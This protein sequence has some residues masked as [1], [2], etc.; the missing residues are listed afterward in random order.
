[1]AITALP[2]A[3]SRTTPATFSTQ[4][5]AF[6]AALGLFV[7][8]ANALA[9]AMNLNDTTANST[10]SVAI[11][12]G[13]KTFTVDTGKSFEPGMSVKIASE[14]NPSKWMHGD[15][16]TY[17]TVTGE[18]V[19]NILQVLSSGTYTDWIVT[20]SAP[21]AENTTWILKSGAD[22]ALVGDNILCDTS[23]GA[24]TITLPASPSVGDT[25]R[26]ADAGYDFATYNLTVGRN[27]KNIAG[28]AENL[29]V[30][31]NYEQFMLVF[32]GDTLGWILAQ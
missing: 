6:V 23:G 24:F 15:V 11:G 16:T 27:S 4:A 19:T 7:T 31:A 1:M 26:F 13:A 2:T 18:L 10:T 22:T 5:D 8:E 12:T 14:A 3:P 9:A 30:S 32:S 25:V 28:K 21:G 17:N 20:L 29:T